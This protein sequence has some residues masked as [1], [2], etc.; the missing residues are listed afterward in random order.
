MAES[1]MR[2]AKDY[3]LRNTWLKHNCANLAKDV[4]FHG[5][6]GP[7]RAIIIIDEITDT[8]AKYPY[9]YQ[10]VSP[11]PEIHREPDDDLSKELI[12]LVNGA[13]RI[14][15]NSKVEIHTLIDNHYEKVGITRS[16]VSQRYIL[17][18]IN[19]AHQVINEYN[20]EEAKDLCMMAQNEIQITQYEL[21]V[22]CQC[23]KSG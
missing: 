5:D 6:F 1:I 16:H 13:K 3:W 10:Y 8:I 23:G 7:G 2:Q 9:L 19:K 21:L 17:D 18:A 14:L 11:T 15:E 4:D 22:E 20:F 12:S